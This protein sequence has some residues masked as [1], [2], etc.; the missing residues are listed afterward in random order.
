MFSKVRFILM[1]CILCQFSIDFVKGFTLLNFH[2]SIFNFQFSILNPSPVLLQVGTYSFGADDFEYAYR[3]NRM[4]SDQT[5]DECLALYI[6][7]KLKI[8]AAKDAGLDTLPDIINRGICYCHQ[9]AAKCLADTLFEK[10]TCELLDGL[11][12]YAITDSVV[13]SKATRDSVGLRAFYEKNA[14]T[15]QWERRMNATIYYCSDEKVAGRIS[16][17]VIKKNEGKG[18]LP[19]GLSTFFCH[20]DGVSPCVDTVR[21]TFPKGANTVADRITWKKGC[22]KILKCNNKYLFLDVHSI[23]PPARKT[24]EEAYGAAIAGYQNE[25]ENKWVEQLKK[26]YPVIIYEEVWANLKKKY[27]N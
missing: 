13:W 6:P 18:R 17:M 2:F 9:L 24:F 1:I 14:H 7:Y 11:L 23:I 26:K 27:A 15:Y 3:K 4:V 21:R 8:A 12:L 20:A 10:I 25:L 19:D 5:L 22:S 16:R